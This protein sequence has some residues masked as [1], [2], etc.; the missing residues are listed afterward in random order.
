MT[1]ISTPR[2]KLQL[3]QLQTWIVMSHGEWYGLQTVNKQN[4]DYV[5][6]NNFVK[7]LH[8]HVHVHVHVHEYFFHIAI[9]NLI[10][11]L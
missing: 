6:R 4:A 7:P 5:N 11:N 10:T 3:D 1:L 8:V 9:C 2:E